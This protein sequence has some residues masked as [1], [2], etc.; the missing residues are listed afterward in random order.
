MQDS[1]QLFVNTE[2][3]N[4]NTTT[5]ELNAASVRAAYLTN[6]SENGGEKVIQLAKWFRFSLFRYFIL[7]QYCISMLLSLP[8]SKNGL[9]R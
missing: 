8:S 2:I 7:L 1:T 4:E 9:V 3:Q 6:Y 5:F